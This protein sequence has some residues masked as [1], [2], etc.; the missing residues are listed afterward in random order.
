MDYSTRIATI[1]FS[2]S[3]RLLISMVKKKVLHGGSCCGE[4]DR[5]EPRI[6]AADKNITHYSYHYRAIIDGMV[7]SNCTTRVEN[8]LNSREGIYAKADN[9]NGQ[10]SIHAKHEITRRDVVGWLEELPYTLM[11]FRSA[12]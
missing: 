6:K 9:G 5:L 8:A 4:H 2:G 11:E 3:I 12:G 10:V 1:I 7:C